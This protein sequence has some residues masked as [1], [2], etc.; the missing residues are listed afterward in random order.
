MLT[1]DAELVT[2]QNVA[3]PKELEGSVIWLGNNGIL[4]PNTAQGGSSSWVPDEVKAVMSQIPAL[5]LDADKDINVE[6]DVDAKR[7][8]A[9]LVKRYFEFVR[10]H[11]KAQRQFWK[12]E[13]GEEL[14]KRWDI[15]NNMTEEDLKEIKEKMGEKRSKERT[16][17][18]L[19]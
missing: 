3:I 4:S 10:S 16:R 11:T 1:L 19:S 8:Y 6:S 15:V 9:N 18:V 2:P 13:K 17:L 12:R 5:V 7:H 14:R